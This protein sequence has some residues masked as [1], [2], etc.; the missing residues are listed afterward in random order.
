MI[1]RKQTNMNKEYSLENE[2]SLALFR[3]S[4]GRLNVDQAREKARQ[5]A[6]YLEKNL[7][8]FGHKG[9]NW[10]AKNWLAVM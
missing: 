8:K 6:P 3:F 10:Y 1:Q 5:V 9:I 7:D 4:Y 2:L